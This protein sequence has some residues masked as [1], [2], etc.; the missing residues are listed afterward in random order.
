MKF[1]FPRTGIASLCR[2]FGK[3]RHAWYDHQW[4]LKQA[5]I[6]EEIIV[7]EV[8]NIRAELPRLGTRKLH[9]LLAEKLAAHQIS[10]GR[11]KLFDMLKAHRLLVK[12]RRRTISTT[13]SHHWLFKYKNLIKDMTI[14]RP[15]QLWVSDITYIRMPGHFGYLSLITDAYSRK[16][17]GYGFREDLSAEGCIDALSMALS[18]RSEQQAPLI[19][20]SDRGVQYCSKEYVDMLAKANID[21]SM[22]ENGDP[23]ENALAERINGILKNEFR[24]YSSPL[25]FAQTKAQ[26]DQSIHAYNHLR[27]HSSCDY[28]TPQ[29]AHQQ[30]GELKKRWKSYPK[31]D[32]QQKSTTF[33]TSRLYNPK[34][35]LQNPV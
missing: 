16:I 32:Q 23:Y 14:Q 18:Q 12:N 22:T 25:G 2:L 27:P 7:Q 30:T 8:L 5:S 33:E 17:M 9:H 15:D 3:T 21:I 31:T 1:D 13:N 20:H 34:Q 11:D 19:H 10:I 35:D 28:L 26:I 24:L 4:R 29:Q 6:E